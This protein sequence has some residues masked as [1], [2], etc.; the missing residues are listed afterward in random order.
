MPLLLPAQYNIAFHNITTLN[1]LSDNSVQQATIDRTGF[2]WICTSEGLNRYDGR[3]MKNYYKENVPALRNNNIREVLCD[4][5]NRLWVRS[6][7]GYIAMLDEQRKWHVIQPKDSGRNATIFNIVQTKSKGI[8]LFRGRRQFISKPGTDTTFIRWHFKDDSVFEQRLRYYSHRSDNEIIWTGTNELFIMDYAIGKITY[9]KKIPN[10]TSACAYSKNELYITTSESGGLYK[11]DILTGHVTELN[12]LVDQYGVTIFSSLQTVRKLP[13][14]RLLITS[15]FAGLYIYDPSNQSLTRF[16][17]DPLNPRSV[18]GNNYTNINA[19]SSG[20]V[21]IG[22]PTSGL[23]YFNV[24]D[25]PATWVG[26]ISNHQGDIFDG[27]VNTILPAGRPDAFWLGCYNQLIL[28]DKHTGKGTFYDYGTAENGYANRG[29]DEV[30]SMCRDD[31]N[32]LWIGTGNNG[33]TILNPSGKVV[34]QI[35]TTEGLPA[36]NV[37]Y[38]LHDSGKIWIT[39]GAGLSVADASSKRVIALPDS[40]ALLPLAQKSCGTIWKDSHNNLWVGTEREGAYRYNSTIGKL[41]NFARPKDGS[42]MEVY[43]FEED[44][45]GKIYLGTWAGLVVLQNDT[46]FTTYSRL[47]GL[48]GDRCENLLKDAAGNIWIDNHTCIVRFNPVAKTFTVF[49]EKSGL[50]PLG[51]APRSSYK[52]AGGYFYFGSEKGFSFFHPDSIVEPVAALKL[53]VTGIQSKDNTIELTA[54]QT[55]SS[56]YNDNNVVI[57]FSAIDLGQPR[58]IDYRYKLNGFDQQWINETNITNVHYNALSPGTYDFEI[59]ASAD[60]VTWTKALYPVKII[61][62]PAI[63]QTGWFRFASALTLA[64]LFYFALKQREKSIEAKA[65]E[66]ARLEE[67]RSEALQ[68]QLEIE[69]VINYFASSL[70]GLHTVDDI[71]WDVVKTCISQLGFQ[72]C[73]IYFYNSEKTMLVQKAAYGPKNIDYKDIYNRI[74]I[75]PGHGVVGH[76]AKTGIAEIIN[77]TSADPRY[78]P[79]DAVRLSEMAVPLVGSDGVM[80]VIDSEHP[81]KGFYTNRHLQILTAI[82]SMVVNKTEQLQAEAENRIKEVEMARLQRDVATL[83]LTATRAQMNPH[84]IFNALNSVQQYILQGNTD[85]ANK[86][87]SRFSRLQREILNHCDR[88]FISLQKEMDMLRM[89]LQLEQLRFNGTFDFIISADEDLDAEEIKIP[90]MILQPFVE[91]AI[92]HGLMPKEGHRNV[93]VNFR[94]DDASS[95]LYCV[96]TDNGIGRQA[97]ADKKNNG[98]PQSDYVSKGLSLV[99]RRL[100]LL[101]AQMGRTFS[102]S[103]EDLVDEDGNGLG[104]RVEVAMFTGF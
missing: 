70:S 94:I 87:L 31:S 49:D 57:Y 67:M 66:K 90:P 54:A 55:I 46:L 62:Q 27:F 2:V 63:W 45:A 73:V 77:D 80:G 34:K 26:T 91:N 74:E 9:R 64:L 84:F 29:N 21:L 23:T 104:T 43:A 101:Q 6:F 41:S 19:D 40:I 30:L 37:N 59:E 4:K 32:N 88:P 78:I 53:S 83:Q 81:D 75:P 51:F 61:I 1:G 89:Y 103:I 48:R 36:N 44:A 60:G 92:W 65:Q 14:N 12:Q 56:N 8:V 76:V 50:S 22:S 58:N 82:A 47:N 97:S 71:L 15:S 52:D 35:C 5:K 7:G 10:I 99:Y 33:I 39:T 69:K 25:K 100:Q 13:D 3:E 72:D 16:M 68:S 11:L 98:L 24:H 102:S 20:Y 28:W 95:M 17:H 96:I 79:D 38:L 42:S 86:Y 93:M 18:P 85:E